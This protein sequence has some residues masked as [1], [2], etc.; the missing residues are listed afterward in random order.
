M[1]LGGITVAQAIEGARRFGE[2]MRAAAPSARDLVRTHESPAQ[3][4]EDD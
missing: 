2:M 3:P 1:S 4:S